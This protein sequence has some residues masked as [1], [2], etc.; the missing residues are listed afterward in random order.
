M[1][2]YK[3]LFLERSE[4]LRGCFEV[5]AFAFLVL[6]FL[7][8]TYSDHS[9]EKVLHRFFFFFTVVCLIANWRWIAEGCDTMIA[10]MSTAY[11]EDMDTLQT[12]LS[13]NMEIE[14]EDDWYS[15][16]PAVSRFFFTVCIKI[17][18]CVR[19]CTRW[20]QSIVLQVSIILSPI[21]LSMLTL[22]TTRTTGTKFIVGTF[23]LSLFHIAFNIA[24]LIILQGFEQIMTLAAINATATGTGVGITGAV[25][26]LAYA[27]VTI[28]AII[29]IA[30]GFLL[31]IVCVYIGLP[32]I[33]YAQMRGDSPMS[34][35][36]QAINMGANLGRQGMAMGKSVSPLKNSI[37]GNK[38][39]GTPSAL[40]KLGTSLA[41]K[42]QAF[43][44]FN[45]NTAE[46][47]ENIKSAIKKPFT[48]G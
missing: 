30:I 4:E 25:A 15:V 37:F 46:G 20:I 28:S 38:D 9:N 27:P 43:N 8:K 33:I 31:L 5:L 16:G 36:M 48:K 14:G 45:K 18:E 7:I 47:I 3:E 19:V 13:N 39:L 1:E 42:G 26:G 41:D 29:L 10:S 40:A 6:S 44:K 12:A 17:G 2:T 21:L 23:A 22:D 11:S 34:A 35:G 32:A 24:D